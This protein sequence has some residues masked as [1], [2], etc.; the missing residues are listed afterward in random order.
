MAPKPARVAGPPATDAAPSAIAL[1]DIRPVPQGGFAARLRTRVVKWYREGE[2]FEQFRLDA[3]NPPETVTVTDESTGQVL[4]RKKA[5]QL[6]APEAPAPPAGVYATDGM[7]ERLETNGEP[8]REAFRMMLEPL[9]LDFKVEGGILWIRTPEKLRTD[10]PGNLPSLESAV[11][12]M[13]KKL[14]AGCSIEFEGRHVSEIV[15]YFSSYLGVNVVLDGRVIAPRVR[16]GEVPAMSE[17]YA[18]NGLVRYLRMEDV[19]TGWA[20]IG[21]LRPLGLNYA[22]Y[23]N[24][25]FASTEDRLTEARPVRPRG[26]EGRPDLAER[27]DAPLSIEFEDRTVAEVMGYLRE[28]TAVTAGIDSGAHGPGGR[29]IAQRT[30]PYIHLE[31]VPLWECLHWILEPL[32]LTYTVRDGGVWITTPDRL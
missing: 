10:M 15:D 27:L 2:R 32:D 25:V 24:V 17:G 20:L 13:V 31:G 11:P 5:S 6:P 9:G 28:Y 23:G 18:T 7:V 19:P 26:L 22:V 14:Q 1:L 29:P 8:L 30:V 3:I 12:D 16:P 4:T 21:T